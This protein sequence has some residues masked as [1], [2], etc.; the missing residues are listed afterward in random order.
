M[1]VPFDPILEKHEELIRGAIAYAR[2]NNLK[3]YKE[4]FVN[5]PENPSS[6]CL[7]GADA[8][9]RHKNQE[10]PS[11]DKITDY[12]YEKLGDEDYHTIT[13]WNDRFQDWNEL[14]AD[15]NNRLKDQR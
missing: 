8:I 14:E 3:H 7:L 4:L 15:L 6:C 12:Y 5:N 9:K 13:A 11:S 1:Q 2:A 10:L